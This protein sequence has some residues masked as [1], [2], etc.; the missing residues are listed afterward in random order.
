V[1]MHFGV[2]AQNFVTGADTLQVWAGPSDCSDKAARISTTGTCQPVSTT[3]TLSAS[4][5]VDIKARDLV[6]ASLSTPAPAS[7]GGVTTPISSDA[8]VCNKRTASAGTPMNVNFLV[9]AAGGGADAETNLAFNPSTQGLGVVVDTIGPAAPTGPS[10]GIGDTLLKIQWTP[11][12]N[13]SD[14]AGFTIFC[15]PPP[16][17]AGTDSGLSL[18]DGTAPIC[19]DASA[20]SDSGSAID[21]TSLSPLGPIADAADEGDADAA[22]AADV[23][24]TPNDASSAADS[25]TTGGT[26]GNS[27]DA[28]VCASNVIQPNINGSVIAGL[29]GGYYV[30]STSTDKT[31]TQATVTGLTNGVQYTFGV[32]A[33]D[34]IGNTGPVTV[35]P[36]ATPQ[37]ISDFWDKYKDDGGGAGG[38]FCALEAV[39]MPVPTTMMGAS[40]LVALIGVL[41]RRKR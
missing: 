41:R 29:G 1:T 17:K 37:P 11:V 36:C 21:G 25:G 23:A 14:T 7:S 6:A 34:L 30:C 15:D 33:S 19:I 13:A 5:T 18:P 3:Y 10:I 35:F 20:S 9:F 8:S 2:L 32:A 27:S 38:G 12:S 24:V 22:D 16:G 26:C 28:G 40:M 39:G 4:F 31:T